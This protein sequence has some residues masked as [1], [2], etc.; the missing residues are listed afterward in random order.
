MKVSVAAQTFSHSVSAA[1]TFLRKLRLK[2][3]KDSKATSEFLM[4]INNL[5]DM[6]NSKRKFGK[7]TKR[8]IT[9]ANYLDIEASLETYIDFLLSL[10]DTSGIPL[11]KGPRQCFVTGFYISAR[12]ILAISKK[13]LQRETLPLEYVLTYC[14]SRYN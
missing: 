4:M 14:L 7:H 10:K 8:P 9:L 6:L 5:F 12:S 1:I 11:I 13:L 2:E 3:F